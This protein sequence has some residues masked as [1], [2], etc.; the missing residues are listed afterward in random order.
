MGKSKPTLFDQIRNADATSLQQRRWHS[1]GRWVLI[2]S[3][4]VALAL[5]FPGRTGE[6]TTLQN[7][8]TM[9][10]TMWTDETVVADYSFPVPKSPD[11]IKR[12]YDSAR[13]S[14]TLVFR[15][16][17]SKRSAAIA[18]L[19]KVVNSLESVSEAIPGLPTYLT[20]ALSGLDVQT[21]SLVASALREH[22]AVIVT[23][24]YRRGIVD[25][26]VANLKAEYVVVFEND[27]SEVMVSTSQLADSMF[28]ARSMLLRSSKLNTVIVA[29][30][31]DVLQS[32]CQ[33]DLTKDN[34][35][36]TRSANRMAASVAENLEIVQRGDIIV[37]KG[38][39]MDRN[40][41]A[42]LSAYRNAQFLRSSGGFNVLVLLGSTLHAT[43]ILSILFFFLYLQR[44]NSWRSLGQMT[45]LVSVVLISGSL[46]LA[47]LQIQTSIP[48]QFLIVLPALSMLI[49]VL[50]EIRTAIILTLVMALTVAG[51][52]SNDY[53]IALVLFMA[54]SLGAYSTSNLQSRTQIFTSMLAIGAGLIVTTLG[55][56]LE[57]ATA[58]D[59]VWPK[60]VASV[61]NAIVSPLLTFA[62]IIV[63]EKVFNVATDLRLEEFDNLSHPLL[64]QLADRAPGTY[65]HTLA[66]ARLSETAA[67]AIGGNATLAK[68]GALFHDI[69][70]LEKSEYFFE[71]QID[72]DNKHD[73]LPPKKSAAI[74]RQHVQDGIDLARRSSLPERIIKF[75]PMHHG[76]ILIKHFYAKALDETLLKET[77]V[78]EQDF[79]YPGPKPDTREAAIVMLADAA[80]ALSRLVDASS[81]DDL[82]AAVEN[83]IVDRLKD[84]QL[85]LAPLSTADL[86]VIRDAFVKNLLGSTHQRVRYMSVPAETDSEAGS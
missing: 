5:L 76:T 41:I 54:G 14:A 53:A 38:A 25:T 49:S 17:T 43:A 66:V 69:G 47:S 4:V 24:A 9:L 22:G 40:V 64:L 8:A 56:D 13:S 21:R 28:F 68:V 1:V 37:R 34:Y 85:S 33:P 11:E 48:L 15:V 45:G 12:E 63:M 59:L 61:G 42:R 16:D 46:A 72:I 75:I 10:G 27:T 26:S 39:L 80:E 77:V 35:L 73:R 3:S 23:A 79:R 67:A 65:Q 36:S 60:L 50:F 51:V 78:D 58:F 19:R 86:E 7:D 31:S 84:G 70:K 74:I 81:R 2:V 20:E 62:I 44:R 82:D 30:A 57:R 55:I 71:N 6:S 32:I 52:R 18:L 83:I 29:L